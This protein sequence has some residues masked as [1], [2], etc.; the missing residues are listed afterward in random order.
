MW[1]FFK[2]KEQENLDKKAD[3]EVSRQDETSP[4]EFQAIV[5]DMGDLSE[6]KRN[7]APLKFWIPE[8]VEN[9]LNEI[10]K[11]NE[12]SLS[13]MLREFLLVHCYGLYAYH[14]MKDIMPEIGEEDSRVMFSK[15]YDPKRTPTYWVTELG[16]NIAPIKVWIPQRLKNDLSILA[17]HVDLTLSNYVR[18]IVISRLLGHGMLPKRP[19]MMDVEPLPDAENW[20][21]DRDVTWKQVPEKEYW[22]W[23]YRL[24]ERREG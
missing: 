9:A 16:K 24:R 21:E 6:L 22:D 15:K 3:P 11:R 12:V 20:A 18:E 1:S 14:V 8:P 4:M 7:N 17:T 13:K 5:S 10:C 23:D 2:Q 19:G